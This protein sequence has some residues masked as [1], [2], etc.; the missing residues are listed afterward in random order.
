MLG[1]T[2]L[3]LHNINFYQELMSS[4]RENIKKRNI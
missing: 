3:T 4:I 2:L 1:S